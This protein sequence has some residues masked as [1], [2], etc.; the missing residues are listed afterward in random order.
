MGGSENK[1]F[2]HLCTEGLVISI[3]NTIR[4]IAVVNAS[5]PDHSIC[6]SSGCL[7]QNSSCMF[8]TL[9]DVVPYA[10]GTRMPNF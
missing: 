7:F 8:G 5:A 4:F 6:S 3:L 2:V 10:T 1:D 9:F